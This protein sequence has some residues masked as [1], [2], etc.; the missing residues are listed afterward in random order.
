[1]RKKVA[2]VAVA[3]SLLYLIGVV[4]SDS[5]APAGILIRGAIAL[6]VFTISA[7]IGG[8]LQ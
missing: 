1:M 2:C 4:G 7:K 3:C 6:T 8:I 5:L